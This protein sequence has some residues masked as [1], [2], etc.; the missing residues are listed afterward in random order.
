VNGLKNR[1]LNNYKFSF[2]KLEVWQASINFAKI[3]YEITNN[4]PNEEKFGLTSQIRRAAISISSNIAEGSAK[5]S[6]KDQARYTEIAFGS[7]LE[8]LNQ[9]ILAFELSYIT[10]SDLCIIRTEIENLSRQINALK[11]SQIRR[12]NEK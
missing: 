12:E 4:F 10:E 1:Q 7:L 5:K 2:E 11:N 8:V 3:V 9:I 6:L